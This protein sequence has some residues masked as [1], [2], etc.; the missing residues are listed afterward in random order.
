MDCYTVSSGRIIQGIALSPAGT[1]RLGQSGRN[2]TQVDVPPPSGSTIRPA[3]PVPPG[4]D[5]DPANTG[6]LV[7]V[8]GEHRPDGAAVV[9]IRDH[10]GFRG[11]WALR[12]A[13]TP[14]AWRIA[15]ATYAAHAAACDAVS[16]GYPQPP[17]PDGHKG[18]RRA[19]GTCPVCSLHAE[20]GQFGP[21]T[22]SAPSD[23]VVIAQGQSAQGIAGHMGGGAE[24]LIVLS[25]GQAIEI[26]CEGR[27]YGA[28]SVLRL[29]NEGGQVTLTDPA[30]AAESAAAASRW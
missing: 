29:A 15:V 21:Y 6:V 5:P 2:R 7:A 18:S 23:L 25:P 4:D 8:P 24:L 22:P 12:T 28:P 11:T 10:S 19:I 30:A 3:R 20:A 26:V 16:F 17:L 9:L 13:R 27:L 14:E 1:I